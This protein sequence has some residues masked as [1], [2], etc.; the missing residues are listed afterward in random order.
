MISLMIDFHFDNY[1]FQRL[2][3]VA[4]RL[5]W[6]RECEHSLSAWHKI[7]SVYS[8]STWPL[9]FKSILSYFRFIQDSI[10]N[11]LLFHFCYIKEAETVI[12]SV[13]QQYEICLLFIQY[14]ISLKMAA[15]VSKDLD[16]HLIYTP[17][18][19]LQV[20]P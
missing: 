20:F 6:Q 4:E 8:S 12:S 14:E 16:R 5:P 3:C 1:K 11:P 15:K 7:F 2:V 19:K 10:E 17:Y 13:Y 18:E 9:F